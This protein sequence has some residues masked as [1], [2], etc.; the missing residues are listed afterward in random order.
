MVVR[1]DVHLTISSA[2]WFRIRDVECCMTPCIP[3]CGIFGAQ[4]VF[5][6]H[7]GC[8]EYVVFEFLVE[9]QGKRPLKAKTGWLKSVVCAACSSCL[10]AFCR[11]HDDVMP[12]N[13]MAGAHSEDMLR[14]RPQ[15]QDFEP[16]ED[17]ERP[18]HA[19]KR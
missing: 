6:V 11:H 4:Q 7:S 12:R 19:G 8:C 10:P 17:E 15:T 16:G 1:G 3:A 2:E 5:G 14:S 13:A 18:R 9:E